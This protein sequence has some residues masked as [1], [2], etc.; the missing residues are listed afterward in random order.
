[1][2]EETPSVRLAMRVIE[3]LIAKGLLRES[4]RKTFLAKLASGK[5]KDEDWKLELELATPSEPAP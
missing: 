5:V 2:T 3:E 1:M 4:S